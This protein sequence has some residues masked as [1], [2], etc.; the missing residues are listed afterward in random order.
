MLQ[1]S[2]DGNQSADKRWILKHDQLQFG[3][4]L[5]TG[6]F[7]NVYEGKKL[8]E[9]RPVAIKKLTWDDHD[10]LDK[11]DRYIH[12]EMDLLIQTTGHANIVDLI[13][14][15]VHDGDTFIVTELIEGGDLHE[16]IVHWKATKNGEDTERL[17]WKDKILVLRDIATALA[18][19]HSHEIVFRD[20]KS[21][22]ILLQRQ[23]TDAT[24][25]SA[26]R[27]I[28]KLCDFGSARNVVEKTK[29][30]LSL[31]RGA[32][33]PIGTEAW[34][35]PEVC[36]QEAYSYPADV[37]SFGI[38]LCEVLL[39][40]N[41]PARSMR[42]AFAFVPDSIRERVVS[43]APKGLWELMCACTATEPAQRPTAEQVAARL[44]SLVCC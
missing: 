1:Q 17:T 2:A 22:N 18:Y 37:F 32:M 10:D 4:Q 30:G 35:A 15:C 34:M 38:V 24:D 40:D 11:V 13:G 27:W 25:P 5:A 8:P 16:N 19:L 14:F 33:T 26:S 6:R 12:R 28:A 42:N 44:A 23:Q 36:M 29:S 31:S 20:V 21:T 9:N 3:H 7:S 41:P 43:D 39:C